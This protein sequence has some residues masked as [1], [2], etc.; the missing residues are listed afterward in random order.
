MFDS[1]L[2]GERLRKMR[3]SAGFSSQEML[4][5]AVNV[6]V[7]TISA[8]ESGKR[9]PD[10]A[11]IHALS[12]KLNCTADYLLLR[13]DGSTHD[14]A[15]MVQYTGLS[16]ESLQ[17]L[18]FLKSKQNITVGKESFCIEGDTALHDFL[19]YALSED[20]TS[21]LPHIANMFIVRAIHCLVH[22]K[23]IDGRS[24]PFNQIEDEELRKKAYR[25]G[26]YMLSPDSAAFHF[27]DNAADDFKALVYNYIEKRA[28]QR[29]L[30]KKDFYSSLCCESEE[31]E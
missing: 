21:Y 23:E 7:Q 24:I 19:N 13:E 20:E 5:N 17:H 30:E 16:E 2:F 8:Y 31:E 11:T 9:L 4:A 28:D 6:S 14:I 18:C 25:R 26:Y 27:V 10:A 3:L 15:H 22:A 29:Y 12:E 1:T